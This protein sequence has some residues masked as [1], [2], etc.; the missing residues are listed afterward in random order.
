MTI[1]ASILARLHVTQ[2]GGNDFGGP[3]FAPKMEALL[4]FVDGV[5]LG[6]ADLAWFDQRAVATAANDDID[7]AGVLSDVFGATLTFA[8]LVALFV[9]NAPRAGAANT[10]ALTI[11][12]GTNPAVG[13]LG[14]TAPTIG[15]IQPGGFLMLGAGHAS[16]IGTVVAGTGDILRV[17]NAAGATANYQIGVIGRSA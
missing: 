8:E 15:P 6:Q 16:G 10:T 9:I 1:E 7:L 2:S 12:G 17:A 5:V 3:Q 14:G 13:F 11:G 4:Q